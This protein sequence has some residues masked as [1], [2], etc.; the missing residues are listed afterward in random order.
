M[1]PRSVRW[2]IT[3]FKNSSWF[4]CRCLAEEEPVEGTLGCVSLQADQRTHEEV[5]PR[6]GSNLVDLTRLR[7]G[8]EEDLLEFGEIE[9][10]QGFIAFEL[11]Y[12]NVVFIALQEMARFE[13][14]AV[15]IGTD[16]DSLNGDGRP[17]ADLILK[18]GVDDR[19]LR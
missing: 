4:G 19:T 3:I 18:V 9:W 12:R 15:H 6:I 14:K 17:F 1:A 7:A 11:K 5:Q 13:P 2:S 8:R 10:S 16:A